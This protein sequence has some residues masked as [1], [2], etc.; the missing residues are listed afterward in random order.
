MIVRATK[1]MKIQVQKR[2]PYFYL[3]ILLKK[4]MTLSCTL[5]FLME[6]A[7][8]FLYILKENKISYRH[9]HN[10][11]AGMLIGSFASKNGNCMVAFKT[12]T[13]AHQ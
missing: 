10:R 12:S 1:V 8:F 3:Y 6:K 2:T 9:G 11:V 5:N 13:I 7:T 4:K